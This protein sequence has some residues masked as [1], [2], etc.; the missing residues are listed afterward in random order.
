MQSLLCKCNTYMV[1]KQIDYNYKKYI[2]KNTQVLECPKCKT[3]YLPQISK[4]ACEKLISMEKNARGFDFGRFIAMLF[5]DK[6]VTTDVEFIYDRNDYYFIPGLRREWNI[7]FLT[8]VFFNIEVLLK[9]CYHPSYS[10]E[11]GADTYGNIYKG[12]DHLISFGINRNGKVLM[13]LGDIAKLDINEQHYLCSENIHSDHDIAS[14]FY[15]GQIETNWAEPSKE[16][17]LFQKR[18]TLHEIILKK[19]SFNLTQLEP[20]T[21]KTAASIFRPI[22]SSNTAFT[23]VII[24]MNKIFVE[25]INN[26]QIKQDLKEFEDLKLDKVG[27]IKLLQYWIEKRIDGDASKIVAPL[28]I[29]YDLRVSFA[30]LQS[31]ETQEKLFAFSC[32]RLGLNKDCRDYIQIYDVL[33][34][35]LH[36]MYDSIINLVENAYLS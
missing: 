8:P 18:T 36:E 32:E 22:V 4:L 25:S 11:L 6:F 26:K 7:G 3:Q 29:L 35:K 23:S 1:L 28:F 14:E 15:E 21:I 27:S 20:E 5:K 24:P 2:F 12:S 13:W 10:L 19:F 17:S 9:Y 34:N 16:K 31:E 30:H 33:I